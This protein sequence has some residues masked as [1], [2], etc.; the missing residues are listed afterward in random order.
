MLEHV[1][2]IIIDC[3]VEALGNGRGVFDG[4]N[5]TY[6]LFISILITSVQLPGAASYDS[7]VVIHTLTANTD[8]SLAR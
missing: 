4:L 7:Q 3:G 5:A 2:N 1:Y 6:K 8:I